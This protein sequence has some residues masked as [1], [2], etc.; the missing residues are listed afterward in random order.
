MNATATTS[1]VDMMMF[2]HNPLAELTHELTL[3]C[4]KGAAEVLAG[5][6]EERRCLE[7]EAMAEFAAGGY[8]LH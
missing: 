5:L 1:L 7:S 6:A 2:Q 3:L 4:L 8:T